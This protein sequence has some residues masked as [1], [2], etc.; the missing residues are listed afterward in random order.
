MFSDKSFFSA[1]V[2]F[3]SLTIPLTVSNASN[4]HKTKIKSVYKKIFIV[5]D[6][7]TGTEIVK[8]SQSRTPRP[9]NG[10]IK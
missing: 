2:V 7:P 1:S 5:N 3:N 4:L 8:A 10:L 9:F 6:P